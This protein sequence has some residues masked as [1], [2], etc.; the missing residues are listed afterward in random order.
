MKILHTADIHLGDLTGPIKDGKNARRMDTLNCMRAV[1]EKAGQEHPNVTVI[2]GDLFNRSRVWADTALED[3]HDA[4]DLFLRPLCSCSDH[5]ALLF[6]TENHDNPKSFTLLQ[7]TIGQELPN[8]HIYTTPQV[9]T[10]ETTDGPVQIVSLPGFDKGRLRTF[11]PGADKETENRNATAL[12]NDVL[13]GLSQQIDRNIP[14]VLMAHYTVAGCEADNGS[15]FLAGRDVVILP[16]TLNMCDFNLT[17]LGH[18]HKP[19]KLNTKCPAFY[20]GSINQLTFNDETD[21]H[22]F[23]IHNIEKNTVETKPVVESEFIQTPE[24]RHCTIRLNCDDIE[25]FIT[26]GECAIDTETIKSKI[27]RVLYNC[28]REQEKALNKSELQKYL[29]DN[30]AFYV[31]GIIPD[32]VDEIQTGDSMKESGSVSEMLLEWLNHSSIEEEQINHIMETAKPLIAKADDGREENKHNG[33]FIPRKIKITNYRS[34]TEAEFDFSEIKMAMVNGPNGVGK[35]SLFMD[36]I[37]DCLYEQTRQEEIGGW[38]REGTKSGSI[39]FEFSMGENIYRVIRTRTRSG[40]GTLALQQL[41]DGEWVNQSDTTMKLTQDKIELLLGMDCT[42]FCSIALIR[43]DAY[44]LFLDASSDRRMEVLSSLLGLDIYSR[45][46]ALAKEK[47]SGIRKQIDELKVKINLLNEKI[48]EKPA[49]EARMG[50]LAQELEKFQ[51]QLQSSNALLEAEKEKMTL[52]NSMRERLDKVTEEYS[53]TKKEIQKQLEGKENAVNE[54]KTAREAVKLLDEA[55]AA[56]TAVKAARFAIEK[57]DDDY[58]EYCGLDVEIS[59]LEDQISKSKENQRVMCSERDVLKTIILE[60]DAITA[61]VE[62]NKAIV[63]SLEEISTK[64]H[65]LS[66]AQAELTEAKN[67]YE[68]RMLVFKGRIDT[69]QSQIKSADEKAAMIENSGCPIGDKAQC[70]FLADAVKSKDSLPELQD[71]LKAVQEIKEAEGETLLAMVNQLKA[72]VD[73]F[74]DILQEEKNLKQ[75]Q[76]ELKPLVDKASDLNTAKAL[77]DKYTEDINSLEE[78]INANETALGIKR[79]EQR[80]LESNAE[81]YKAAEA[82]VEKH[83]PMAE[84]LT[85]CLLAQQKCEALERQINGIDET[86]AVLEEKKDKLTDEM[87]DLNTKLSEYDDTK[88]STLTQQISEINSLIE[89][90]NMQR[91][92]VQKRLDDIEEAE[93]NAKV[94]RADIAAWSIEMENTFKVLQQAFSL[95]GIPYMI[96]RNIVPEIISRSNDILASMTGGKMAVDIRTER[97]LKSNKK[98]V[99]S[100][101]V[102]ISSMTGENR[103]YQSHSGGEKVKIALA[104]TLGLADVKARRVGVQLGMLFI[105]EPPFLDEDGT[106]AY[107]DALMNMANRNPDMRILAISHDPT[108][109]ARFEQNI[110]V[111]GGENG[112]TVSID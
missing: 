35:S 38:V 31:A 71:E 111:T 101:D 97:Q 49:Y 70:S 4:I 58:H 16:D 10:L 96:I 82:A 79:Q 52:Y 53:D 76:A 69:L 8:L 12:I 65:D 106:E 67:K 43:Q 37:C 22:G 39:E 89:N 51:Q 17:C 1:V 44:G 74:G 20:C 85:E 6:G 18:I 21:K 28:S 48:T 24:R 90:T 80:E 42:T 110:T 47:I 9:E 64:R 3:V 75:R 15:T 91:G 103:P 102:W 14:S 23:Y 112:S 2:A 26:K 45:L 59:I 57:F 88:I 108:M 87:N 13:L 61:A 36:A 11:C 34:Y 41:K 32:E 107:A 60:E 78:E 81:A 77:F 63:K 54:L 72:K 73:S 56:E 50:E 29:Y 55:S 62:E 27:V 19:Q 98:V 92:I 68:S 93:D 66:I 109:K 84:K 25:L 105:D 100:L 5:V 104:V 94:C 95:D 99:N 33:S 86:V 40:R 30:G 83:L 46:E 7:Q